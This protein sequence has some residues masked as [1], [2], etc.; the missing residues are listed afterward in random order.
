[1]R[2][3]AFTLI[4]VMVVMA[5]ISIL[6]GMMAPAVWKF[7]ESEEIATTRQRMK[8]LKM[9]MVGDKSLIQNG[10]RTHYGFVGDF[11]TLPFT[12]SS[13]CAFKFLNS[14]ADMALPQYDAANWSGRYLSSSAD[15][16]DYAVDAWGSPIRCAN[17]IF[18]DGRLVGLTL[19]STAPNGVVIE[20]VVDANDVIPTNR[21][22]GNVFGNTT[23]SLKITISPEKH[24]A[25]DAKSIC[26]QLGGFSS[27]T[28][29]FPYNLPI[30]RIN[31]E[32]LR[33]NSSCT[34]MAPN[35]YKYSY[36]VQD[37]QKA[38]KMPDLNIP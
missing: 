3:K 10:V 33:D 31:I 36:F 25:F 24:G 4:E 11:G 26:K 27:Y 9:A 15:P 37:N 38:I 35:Q 6:A 30:G 21:I 19:S 34:T 5:I 17:K 16:S 14:S 32:I 23:T 28:T 22:I 13:S 18:S 7:W 20:E 8:E 2:E 1:M 29:L 12:N